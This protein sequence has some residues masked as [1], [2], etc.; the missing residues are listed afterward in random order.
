[1]RVLLSD[2][3]LVSTADFP[4]MRCCCVSQTRL[5]TPSLTPRNSSAREKSVLSRVWRVYTPGVA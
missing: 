4:L 2:E 3:K 1:M 5:L